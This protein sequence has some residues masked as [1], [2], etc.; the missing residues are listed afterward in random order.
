M[1][2][3]I[4]SLMIEPIASSKYG[5]CHLSG[6]STTPSREMKKFETILPMA[7]LLRMW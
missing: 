1:L 4:P 7:L 5:K 3:S 6:D 2:V